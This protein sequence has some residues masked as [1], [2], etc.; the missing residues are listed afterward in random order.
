MVAT[1]TDQIKTPN[2]AMSGIVAVNCFNENI[3][4]FATNIFT[5]KNYHYYA[6]ILLLIFEVSKNIAKYVFPLLC[7][8]TYALPRILQILVIFAA[9]I[10]YLLVFFTVW[11]IGGTS[12]SG[13][14][15]AR[16]MRSMTVGPVC[17]DEWTIDDVI[18]F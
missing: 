18:I 5:I 6:S 4:L 2:F 9:P 1:V 16:N 8:N 13:N 11:L 7:F 14:V 15:M 10:K 17:D 3:A 12:K